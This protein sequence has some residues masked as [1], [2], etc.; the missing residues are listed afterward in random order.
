MPQVK[1]KSTYGMKNTP[2]E[3]RKETPHEMFVGS[4]F[5][6]IH[7]NDIQT[8]SK[9]N[10]RLHQIY[11]VRLFFSHQ[12]KSLGVFHLK[13]VL[14]CVVSG[15]PS[16]SEVFLYNTYEKCFLV[17]IQLLAVFVSK[18]SV[19][20]STVVEMLSFCL[21]VCPWFSYVAHSSVQQMLVTSNE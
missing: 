14:L 3:N 13:K 7:K 8:T 19:C 15:Y 2:W 21:F 16:V 18:C 5:F 1:R 10:L 9:S 11:I 17:C 12:F 4:T 20:V 6:V